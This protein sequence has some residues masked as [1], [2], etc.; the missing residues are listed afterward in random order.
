MTA[1][2]VRTLAGGDVQLEPSDVNT[3]AANMR[4]TLLKPDDPNYDE[5]RTIWNAMIDRRPALIARCIGAADVM[6]CV[7]FARER[8]LELCIKGGGH[9]IAGLAVSDGAMMIDMSHMRGVW[10]D[11]EN[12]IAHAQAGCTLG[13]VDRDTQLHGLAAVLGFVSNTGITGLTLGGGFGYLT[14][15]FGW[16]SDNVR[17]FELVTPDGRLRRAS[18]A[19]EPDLFWGLRGGGGNFGVVTAIEYDLYAVGPE[20]TGGA[21]AWR[22]EDAEAVLEMFREVNDQAPPEQVCV[23]AIRPAPPAPWLPKEIHGKLIVALFVCDTGPIEQ[24]KKRLASIK[25]FGSPVG[26]I[27]QPRPYTSQQSLLDATQPNGRRYYWKSE[28]LPG[29][30]KGLLEQVIKHGGRIASPHSAILLFP[31]HGAL[32]DL[33]EDH[34]AVGNRKTGMVFNVAGSWEKPEDDEANIRWAREAWNDMR[35]FSTGGT[36]INFLNQEE[37]DDRIRDAYG[38][39]YERLVEIKTKYD[40]GNVFRTNKNVA[41]KR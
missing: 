38:T 19:D 6:S 32:S 27:V 35:E 25:A 13:D 26:D 8:G 20:I 15:R 16:T 21:I 11:K 9:N 18:E 23:A 40:P 2:R 41:P 12:R 4:G 33:A 14:R 22:A 17:S 1:I 10:V 34:S 31:L 28:Y 39:N 29:V 37:G 36:Y 24:A 30:D 5:A 7:D 3:L